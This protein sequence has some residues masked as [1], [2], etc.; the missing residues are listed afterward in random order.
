MLPP[1]APGRWRWNL[2]PHPTPTCSDTFDFVRHV[3]A[4]REVSSYLLSSE[5]TLRLFSSVDG[6]SLNLSCG[7]AVRKTCG[8]RCYHLFPISSISKHDVA[9]ELS[10]A[11]SHTGKA[12]SWTEKFLSASHKNRRTSSQHFSSAALNKRILNDTA[13]GEIGKCQDSAG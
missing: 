11:D 7:V 12:P 4:A 5:T 13:G 8:D 1:C 3:E 10:L 9:I 2:G 6:H